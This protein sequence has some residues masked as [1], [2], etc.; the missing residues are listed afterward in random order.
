[1]HRRALLIT[2]TALTITPSAVIAAA[3]ADPGAATPTPSPTPALQLVA[4]PTGGGQIDN[5]PKGISPGDQFYEHGT[6]TAVSGRH[7]GSFTLTTEL[8]AGS[9]NHGT[10]QSTVTVALPDGQIVTT[11][12][13][14]TVDRFTMAVVGGTGRYTGA[15]GTV[16]ITPGPHD[17]EHATIHLQD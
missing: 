14:R 8:I 3:H 11:G 6:I 5:A 10:E 7:L 4:H 12:G 9:A 15:R 13:H 1:M 17:S 16:S 2:A